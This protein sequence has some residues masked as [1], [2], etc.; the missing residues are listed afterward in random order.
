MTKTLLFFLTSLL[1]SIHSIAQIDGVPNIVGTNYTLASDILDEERKIQVYLPNNYSESGLDY[2]VLYLLDGQLFFN[3]AVSL[4]NKFKQSRLSPEFIIVGI[5]TSY[6]QRFGHFSSGRE[7]FSEFIRKELRPFIVRE[8]RTNGEDILFGWE[9]AASLGFS[10]LLDYDQTFDAYILASP[11]P[12]ED[13]VEKLSMTDSLNA[14]LYFS[15]SPNEYQVNHGTDKLDLWLSGNDIKG[16]NWQYA[17]LGNEVHSST[18]YTTLYHGLRAYFKYYP[19]FQEDS[20]EKFVKAGG[21]AYA[22]AYSKERA[23]RYGFA[24]EL[25]P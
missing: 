1:V 9:Y 19:D 8:F 24:P 18:G 7:N 6:P 13:E 2:P 25:S 11:F 17:E 15:V 5:S 4:S 14:L 23:I 20:L 12:I 10:I 22:V 16:L 3:S 21:L